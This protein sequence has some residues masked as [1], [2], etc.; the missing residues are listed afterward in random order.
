MG[1]SWQFDLPNSEGRKMALLNVEG[2]YVK[3]F[4][5][6]TIGY[7]LFFMLYVVLLGVGYYASQNVGGANTYFILSALGLALFPFYLLL[8]KKEDVP[9]E[10][11]PIPFSK[12]LTLSTFFYFMGVILP[13][14]FL[15]GGKSY[16]FS[17]IVGGILV[18]AS[19]IRGFSP[20][21]LMLGILLLVTPVAEA[22]F[23]VVSSSLSLIQPLFTGD[24]T[25]SS[26]QAFSTATLE[27]SMP[28]RIFLIS[29]VAGT[30]ETL[31]FNYFSIIYA[32]VVGTLL[33]MLVSAY[34][35]GK[36]VKNPFFVKVFAYIL[37]SL[38]FVGAHSLN[39][40]YDSTT[41]FIIAGMFLFISNFLMFEV[42]IPIEFWVGLHKSL[43]LIFMITL[44]G[45]AQVFAGFISLIGA[46]YLIFD[47][48]LIPFFLLRNKDAVWKDVKWHFTTLFK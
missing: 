15:Y 7:V 23:S 3:K 40:S 18:I 29:P 19:F 48:V 2:V 25:S 42:G 6:N 8:K 33:L 21:F 28:V 1:L 20:F 17:I 5:E 45:F 34:K 13:F 26:N 43:N 4:N 30:S 39:G 47:L 37:S 41:K 22:N 10:I 32:T 11:F 9:S 31:N 38:V 44:F 46:I 14:V 27:G 16:L 36:K 24:F 12:K 35:E